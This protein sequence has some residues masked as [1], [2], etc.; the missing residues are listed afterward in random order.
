LGAFLLAERKK[1][2]GSNHMT[3]IGINLVAT[4][5]PAGYWVGE[6]TV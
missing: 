1:S 4:S 3:C 5:G 6:K 2:K